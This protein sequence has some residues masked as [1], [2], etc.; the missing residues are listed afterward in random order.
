MLKL[1]H[2]WIFTIFML[3]TIGPKI[4]NIWMSI[5]IKVVL[6]PGSIAVSQGIQ[7]QRQTVAS[8]ASERKGLR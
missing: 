7:L 4:H 1:L 2:I 6:S 3:T 8:L 5:A